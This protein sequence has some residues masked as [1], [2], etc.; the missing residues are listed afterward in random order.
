MCCRTIGL[1][2][3]QVHALQ[4]L[5]PAASA[6]QVAALHAGSGWTGDAETRRAA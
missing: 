6:A 5:D 4:K 1:F 3:L 2:D